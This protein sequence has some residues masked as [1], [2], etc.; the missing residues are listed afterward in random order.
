MNEKKHEI[1]KTALELFVNNGFSA[2][3]TAVVAQK[4]KVANGT[5]FHYFPTKEKLICALYIEVKN[6]FV[7]SI[8]ETITKTPE[9]QTESGLYGVI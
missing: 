8:T 7:L 2:T 3:P 4:A 6:N 9:I 1:L 5:L